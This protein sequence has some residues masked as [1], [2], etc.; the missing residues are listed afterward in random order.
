[1]SKANLE[2]AGRK[3]DYARRAMRNLPPL[4]ETAKRYAVSLSEAELNTIGAMIGFVRG[5]IED[6][7]AKEF[8]RPWAEHY[9]PTVLLI[10]K[11]LDE[12]ESST[13]PET[14]GRGKSSAPPN[15][16]GSDA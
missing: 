14:L 13:N 5:A 8:F 15:T 6:S 11:R 12:A 2:I 7:S 3:I 4:G 1:M 9:W 16:Q 10:E